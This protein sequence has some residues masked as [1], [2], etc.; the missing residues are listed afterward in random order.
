MEKY[1]VQ[2]DIS[3][4]IVWN[5]ETRITWD[6]RRVYY[7][8]YDERHP[9]DIAPK[10][11]ADRQTVFNPRPRNIVDYTSQDSKEYIQVQGGVN[12]S[13]LE[14]GS[15]DPNNIPGQ[16]GINYFNV[17]DD[18]IDYWVKGR[19]AKYVR[20]PFLAERMF[21]AVDGD[22]DS[23]YYN[24]VKR[25]VDRVLENGSIPII[26]MHGYAEFTISGVLYDLGDPEYTV[27]DFAEQWRKL[28]SSSG[29][30]YNS[31]I[32]FDLM[33]E[34]ELTNFTSDGW[35]T[36]LNTVIA[37]IRGEGANNVLHIEVGAAS[38]VAFLFNIDRARSLENLVDSQNNWILHLHGYFDIDF[39][40]GGDLSTNSDIDFMRYY[41]VV[42]DFV[43][44]L[45]STHS[46][47]QIHHGEFG[48]GINTNGDLAQQ[49]FHQFCY[50]NKDII[51][52][53]TIWGGGDAWGNYELETDPDF[54]Q[55]EGNFI[56]GIT[57][58]P[59][60]LIY[61]SNTEIKNSGAKAK[62][63]KNFI[64]GNTAND[65]L[66]ISRNSTG[67]AQDIKGIYKNFNVNTFRHTDRGIYIDQKYTNLIARDFIGTGTDVN[68][69]TNSGQ[70]DFTGGSNGF[71]ITEDGSGSISHYTS[72]DSSSV[73][74]TD[75]DYVFTCLINFR[76]NW[77]SWLHSRTP[78]TFNVYNYYD[79]GREEIAGDWKRQAVKIS[80]D[81]NT[82]VILSRIGFQPNSSPSASDVPDAYEKASPSRIINVSCPMI[83]QGTRIPMPI[84][85]ASA[86]AVCEKDDIS[87]KGDALRYLQ[88]NEFTIVLEI[89][90]LNYQSEISNIFSINGTIA[91][92]RNVDNSVG[93]D[94]ISTLKT[95]TAFN[96]IDSFNYPRRVA[97]SY[98]AVTE[99]VLTPVVVIAAEG[100]GSPVTAT[101]NFD[102]ITSAKI[103]TFGG[104]LRKL[105]I[106]NRFIQGQELINILEH[107]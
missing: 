30:G 5:Y 65:I 77:W 82:S 57:K 100:L 104:Y 10:P 23:T 34:P 54:I 89:A 18:H 27:S 80:R 20:I 88:G 84:F 78:D 61:K 101:G 3:G 75:T 44:D 14:F 1:K 32:E 17:P 21:T 28:A 90:E 85:S 97:L 43:Y 62:I 7:K 4:Q 92:R 99:T 58:P 102:S 26:D 11:S 105:R 59:V 87:F 71:T 69:I 47:L 13:G 35:I 83:T 40:G 94:V 74:S 68:V 106:Y 48:T 24:I 36:A 31:L 33:N 46:G 55:G 37:A 29:F 16:I 81:S 60:K 98:K 67:Y 15:R 8:Y 56:G 39:N 22:I 12:L 2:C 72:I 6:G 51:R 19:K 53:W 76:Q 103:E 38:S 79:R 42:R 95:N 49:N 93:G 45:R 52:S 63:N 9:Q 50:E 107:Y 86:N 96:N 73:L 70:T 66:T 41:P 25:I 91:L 64:L